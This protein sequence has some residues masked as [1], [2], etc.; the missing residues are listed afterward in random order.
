MQ[1][2]KTAMRHGEFP[3]GI[4]HARFPLFRRRKSRTSGCPRLGKCTRYRPPG[5]VLVATQIVGQ[6]VDIDAEW[7]ISELAP[8]DMLLQRMDRVWLHDRGKRACASPELVVITRD[9]SA[10]G[11]QD[12][13]VDSLGKENCCVYAPYVLMRPHGLERPEREE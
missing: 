8:T 3:A 9:P 7:M 12:E 2:D 5:C 1:T 10:A 6:S 13:A 11:S 4:K